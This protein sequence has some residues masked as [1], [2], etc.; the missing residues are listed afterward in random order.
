MVKSLD[1]DIAQ[2]ANNVSHTN[3][4]KEDFPSQKNGKKNVPQ[5]SSSSLYTVFQRVYPF[6]VFFILWDKPTMGEQHALTCIPLHLEYKRPTGRQCK[7]NIYTTG[8]A[9]L[10]WKIW[11]K[12]NC[13]CSCCGLHI[14]YRS[15]VLLKL[16][17][18][19]TS[20]FMKYGAVT[21]PAISKKLKSWSLKPLQKS[22]TYETLVMHCELPQCSATS[23]T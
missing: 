12:I 19:L 18:I 1:T 9:W 20:S 2:P 3:P 8:P 16:V 14:K 5:V 15:S 7:A 13:I 6:T 22:Y 21:H 23:S 17:Y 11:L 4:H 10:K